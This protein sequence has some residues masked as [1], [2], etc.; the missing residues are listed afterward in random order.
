MQGEKRV[1]SQWRNLTNAISARWW[2]S[3]STVLS[4]VGS[5]SAYQ[6]HE[7]NREWHCPLLSLPRTLQPQSNH[8]RSTRNSH[9]RD[10]QQNIWQALFKNV[11]VNKVAGAQGDMMNQC[12]V[13]SW[14]GSWTKLRKSERNVEF[15]LTKKKKKERETNKQKHMLGK[16]VYCFGF[17]RLVIL[18]CD[19]FL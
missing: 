3:V 13:I 16:N 15:S 12:H 2:K 14:M 19:G 8:D 9:F 18:P 11:K 10:G 1:T 17:D 6:C 7:N 5:V 4:H